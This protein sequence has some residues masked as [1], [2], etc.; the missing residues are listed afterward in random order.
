MTTNKVC[1]LGAGTKYGKLNESIIE[2]ALNA[3]KGAIES[4]GITPKRSKLDT[5][6][7]FSELQTSR[8]TWRLSS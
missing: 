8:F 5:F 4:A 3:A 6:Q 7:M 2:I 1:L